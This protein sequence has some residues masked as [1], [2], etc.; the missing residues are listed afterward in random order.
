MVIYI[1]NNF[2]S[3]PQV[4]TIGRVHDK[5]PFLT[6]AICPRPCPLQ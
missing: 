2:N 4:R 1:R 6:F 3:L 5:F